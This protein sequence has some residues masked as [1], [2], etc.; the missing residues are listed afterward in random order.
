MVLASRTGQSVWD[1]PGQRLYGYAESFQELARSFAKEGVTNPTED[2][3]QLLEQRRLAENRQILCSNFAEMAQIIRNTAREVLCYKPLEEKRRRILVHALRSEG[4]YA[5]NLC[6]TPMGSARDGIGMTLYTR[7]RDGRNADEVADMLSV[8]LRKQLR[9]SVTSPSRVDEK[10]KSF[11]FVEEAGFMAL[12]GFAKVVKENETV[13]GDNYS[14][15]ESERGR[16]TVLLSD[17]TGSGEAACADSTLVL[18]LMEKMLEAGYRTQTA[19][20]LVNSVIFSRGDY[21]GH[22]TL[23][24]CELDLYDGNCVFSKIGGTSSFLKRGFA[25]EAVSGANLPLGIFQNVELSP[26]QKKLEDGD[27]LIMMTDGVLDALKANDYEAVMTDI[28][29]G[30]TEKNPRELAEKL[31]HLVICL[32]EGRIQDDMTIVVTG[33]WRNAKSRES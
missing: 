26:I 28:I 18:D 23:D 27:Y 10:K 24:I 4:I 30:M 9:L 33:V 19:V 3:Q 6:Y 32:S 16:M 7:K 13:S 12:T 8:L 11:I 2:R 22:P 17:G 14:L 25:A 5:E 31:L 20:N 21:E 15:L 1:L 29:A